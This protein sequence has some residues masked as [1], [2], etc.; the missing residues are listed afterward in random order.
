MLPV[1]EGVS[2][3]EAAALPEAV[4]TAWSNLVGVAH[5]RPQETVLVHGGSGGVGSIAIQVAA[6]HG[7]RVLTTAGGPERA[8]RC[9]GL[10]ADVVVDHRADDFVQV[11]AD[12]TDGRGADVILDVVGA[13]YLARNV[14]TL[15][16][17]GRLV[18][19]G[20]QQGRRGELDLGVL[21]SKR[22]SVAA[23]TLRARP[24]QEKAAIVAD[25][26]ARVWPWVVDG[27][28]R[29]VVHAVFP[30]AEAARAQQAVADGEAFGKVLLV[31]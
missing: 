18:V 11:V 29:P 20:F 12:V 17:G 3:V 6:A 28:V 31:V 13:A 14:A 21:S 24:V 10:G 8:A 9:A 15:A 30:L 16:T 5:L 19:I 7:A 22:A 23:T 26:R 2:L 27:A 25:V 1:P 4:C